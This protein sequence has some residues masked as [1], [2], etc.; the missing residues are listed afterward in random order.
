[1]IKLNDVLEAN[2][3][4]MSMGGDDQLPRIASAA[5]ER[6]LE[7]QHRVDRALAYAATSPSA[8][9]HAR[10]MARILDGSITVDD[11]ARE[12]AEHGLPMHPK[13]AKAVEQPKKKVGGRKPGQKNKE[14]SLQGRSTRQRKEFRDWIE[15]QGIE[16]AKFGPVPQHY[17][18]RFDEWQEAQ[19][20]ARVQ[21]I[22]QQTT[23]QADESLFEQ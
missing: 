14:R 12:I 13:P 17:V 3:L 19:R 11:E 2:N 15:S 20:Q 9:V 8:S 7:L 18:D 16:L 6:S 22:V 23:K 21:G 1:M 4:L 10:N 5:I